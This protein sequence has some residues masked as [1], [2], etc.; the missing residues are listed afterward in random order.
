MIYYIHKKETNKIL[1]KINFKNIIDF[2]EPLLKLE[3]FLNQKI[4]TSDFFKL[5]ESFDYYFFY[6]DKSQK[7]KKIFIN[8][9]WTY[10]IVLLKIKDINLKSNIINYENNKFQFLDEAPEEKLSHNEDVYLKMYLSIGSSHERHNTY[11]IEKLL[12]L[13]YL[14]IIKKLESK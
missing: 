4:T 6:Y 13:D 8:Q 1:K 2:N 12:N 7:N 11:L 10:V 14:E 9:Q 3:S 5:K